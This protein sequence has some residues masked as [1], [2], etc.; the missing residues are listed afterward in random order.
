MG[1]LMQSHGDRGMA[2]RHIDLVVDGGRGWQIV[3]WCRLRLNQSRGWLADSPRTG[4]CIAMHREIEMNVI[5]MKNI[6]SR[7]E[8][9][10]EARAGAGLDAYEKGAR[11]IVAARPIALNGDHASVGEMEAA[12]INGIAEG[13]FGNLRAILIVHAATGISPHAVDP[14]DRNAEG[15]LGERLH[16]LAEPC[17]ECGD[18]GAIDRIGRVE[19]HRAILQGADFERIIETAGAGAVDGAD[20]LNIGALTHEILGKTGALGLTAPRR[21]LWPLE[22]R[23]A[24]GEKQRRQYG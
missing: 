16:D 7:R 23:T 1:S 3:L 9:S 6:R 4:R 12:N 24:L 10:G 15:R 21:P 2:L 18:H 8:D 20:A 5:V 17:I 22:I 11:G 13:M 19:S 14:G